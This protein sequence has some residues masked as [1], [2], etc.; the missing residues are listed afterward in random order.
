VKYSLAT[1]I[2]HVVNNELKSL[3]ESFRGFSFKLLK[4]KT[5]LK[6]IQKYAEDHLPRLGS[7][8]ARTVFGLGS[9]KILKVANHTSDYI[10]EQNIAEISAYTESNAQS[11]LAKI[12]DFDDKNYFW[13]VEEAV[14]IFVDNSSMMSKI[15]PSEILL[16]VIAKTAREGGELSDAI[17]KG[18]KRHN[19]MYDFI[20]VVNT[21]KKEIAKEELTSTDL[22]LFSKVFEATKVGF[23]DLTR[24]DH[25]G[26][27]TDGRLVLADYGINNSLSKEE[28]DYNS[29][30]SSRGFH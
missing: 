15:H 18:I 10:I 24:Y 29:W 25:W 30:S 26:T 1:Y 19:N 2:E 16:R 6:E 9:G 22:E 3:S 23:S 28:G 20:G 5:D 27:T 21:Q 12:Y 11:F 7:G 17:S 8:G 13:V 14:K 4:Q